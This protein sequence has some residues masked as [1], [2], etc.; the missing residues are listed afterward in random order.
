MKKLLS[1]MFV[2][3]LWGHGE[4]LGGRIACQDGVPPLASPPAPPPAPTF[5]PFA[6]NDQTSPPPPPPTFDPFGG[7]APSPPIRKP[8]PKPA[9]PKVLPHPQNLRAI[10]WS[11]TK[12]QAEAYFEGRVRGGI[13]TIHVKETGAPFEGTI[14][15]VL[16]DGTKQ[17][18]ISVVNGLLHGEEVLLS[19]DGKVVERNWFE[20]GRLVESPSSATSA[21]PLPKTVDQLPKAPD[22][23]LI[24]PS[25]A[26]IDLSSIPPPA[27]PP[28]PPVD[29][30]PP[31]PPQVS[32]QLVDPFPR[33]YWLAKLKFNDLPIHFRLGQVDTDMLLDLI[34]LLTG[35]TIRKSPLL[36]RVHLHYTLSSKGRSLFFVKEVLFAL[37]QLLDIHGIQLVEKDKGFLDAIPTQQDKQAEDRNKAHAGLLFE[38]R[39][40]LDPLILVS[41]SGLDELQRPLRLRNSSENHLYEIMEQLLGNAIILRSNQVSPAKVTCESSQHLSKREMLLALERICAM[42]GSSLASVDNITL[43]LKAEAITRKDQIEAIAKWSDLPASLLERILL[44]EV[45]GEPKFQTEGKS[46]DFHWARQGIPF[47]MKFGD[48]SELK[49]IVKIPL[50]DQSRRIPLPAEQLTRAPVDL[51]NRDTVRPRLPKPNS[52]VRNDSPF[53]NPN[54]RVR[55]PPTPG[56][57]IPPMLRARNR[58]ALKPLLQFTN[59]VKFQDRHLLFLTNSATA[60]SQWFEVGDEKAF[61]EWRCKF[62]SFESWKEVIKLET[63]FGEVVLPLQEAKLNS[64]T[65]EWYADGRPKS[66]YATIGK[67]RIGP[68]C[69]WHEN[70]LIREQGYFQGGDKLFGPFKSWNE[71]GRKI[72]EGR[73]KE[74]TKDGPWTHWYQNGR[75]SARVVWKEGEFQQVEVWKPN[76]KKCP[77]TNFT[78]GNGVI[79]HYK[80]DGAESSR[81]TLKDGSFSSPL[82]PN[83]ALGN[84]ILSSGLGVSRPRSRISIPVPSRSIPRP[85]SPSRSITIPRP[86]R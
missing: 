75:I 64:W 50:I 58:P 28:R 32:G 23:S 52:E 36:S 20:K 67:A 30:S 3:L 74:G 47:K 17:G 34:G 55:L 73:C 65:S 13:S 15:I 4:I 57:F 35:K 7:N 84:Y 25:D 68:F 10:D 18:H 45:S 29:V 19:G 82:S 81:R 40:E 44:H 5:D 79:V 22:S 48:G 12:E 11:G 78:N 16:S 49:G 41:V 77:V 54:K 43:T 76:G 59:Y 39:G 71:K 83:E 1:T 53:K 37:D 70:G 8:P 85:P 42:S 9:P 21:R 60:K 27:L 14:T 63:E 80:E 56:S 72:R 24:D 31:G 38:K 66:E 61:S 6:D 86:S 62:I 26:E 46:V 69:K 2:A 33:P 51:V